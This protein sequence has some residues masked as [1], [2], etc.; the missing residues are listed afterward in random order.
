GG[1]SGGG[2]AARDPRRGG[3]LLNVLE[4]LEAR[5]DH[6][7]FHPLRA[8][9]EAMRLDQDRNRKPLSACAQRS[10]Q[11]LT[12][13]AR[14]VSLR[15]ITS[16][17]SP[18]RSA[19]ASLPPPKES[20]KVE[21]GGVVAASLAATTSARL[22]TR[23]PPRTNCATRSGYPCDPCHAPCMICCWPSCTQRRPAQA[24]TGRAIIGP[25]AVLRRICE[26]HPHSERL[27][28]EMAPEAAVLSRLAGAKPPAT[29]SA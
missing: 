23:R 3:V 22:L 15:R 17:S 9:T 7:R 26:H 13:G 20:P 8:A 24:P 1:G 14:G 25:A 21:E 4:R 11:I 5:Q 18:A 28:Q 19:I 29:V 16:P 2:Q 6:R 12:N 27:I 10:C